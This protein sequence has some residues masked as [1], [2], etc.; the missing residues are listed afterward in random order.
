MPLKSDIEVGHSSRSLKSATQV[1][2]AL[3]MADVCGEGAD[4]P[5]AG[6]LRC[7]LWA[8]QASCTRR[9]GAGPMTM[10]QPFMAAA[11]AA[12]VRVVGGPDLHRLLDVAR[13]PALHGAGGQGTGEGDRPAQQRFEGLVSADRMHELK[14]GQTMSLHVNGFARSVF[15]GTVRRI[16]A[17]AN[18]TARQV[19]VIVAFNDAAAA[20]RVS[21][22]FAE[23]ARGNG[24]RP[25]VDAG[26]RLG[27]A[28]RRSR[29]RAAARWPSSWR[30]SNAGICFFL[31]V[32]TFVEALLTLVFVCF[33]WRQLV[34][35]FGFVRGRPAGA[36]Q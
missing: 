26:R 23:R 12:V 1:G 14:I 13:P 24:R 6:A 4:V 19:K 11:T 33:V 10:S 9:R 18:A 29:L 35:A 36:L 8:V 7:N 15:V 17:A 31:S 21:G 25:G 2:H 5:V 16:D 32:V 30:V 3:G 34:R 28:R 20:P 22:P 27:G